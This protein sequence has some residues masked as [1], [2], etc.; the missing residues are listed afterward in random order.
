MAIESVSEG[1]VQSPQYQSTMK[2]NIEQAGM[3]FEEIAQVACLID[4]LCF[5]GAE[6]GDSAEKYEMQ[7]R[8][9]RGMVRH[10]GWMADLGTGKVDG[11]GVASIKGCAEHWMMCPAY[12][13]SLISEKVSH[14]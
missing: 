2:G 11:T 3:L 6:P 7:M 14:A 5:H 13:D 12:V 9:V 10:I 1:A 4:E 8:V